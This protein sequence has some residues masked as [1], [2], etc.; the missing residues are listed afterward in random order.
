VTAIGFVGLG[1]MGGRMVPRLLAAGHELAVYDRD[2]AALARAVG[3][4]ARACVSVRAV[5]EVAETVLVSL[6]TPPIV[7]DVACGEGGLLGGSALRTYVDLST[8]GVAIA[9]EVGAALTG[10]G[11]RCVDAPVSG[12]VA[13][14]D[15][16]T[17]TVM[18]A[19]DG[20]AIDDVRPLLERIGGNIFVVGEHPGAAQLAKVINNLLSATAI[21]VTAEASALAVKGGLDAAVLLDALAVSSGTNTAVTDKFPRQVLTRRFDQGFRL[22]LMAKDVRLCLDA[23]QRA[24]APM[25]ASSLIGSLWELAVAKL[26]AG[27]DCTEIAKLIE[28]WAGVTIGGPA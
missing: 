7:R 28:E 27:A 21:L 23:A 3:A 15:A 26:P 6:P 17:L 25:L 8:T 13:G 24:G 14:A 1:E 5:A 22:E 2:P 4:G 20:A 19:G 16:G 11:V 12:G 9:E 10:A 18:V